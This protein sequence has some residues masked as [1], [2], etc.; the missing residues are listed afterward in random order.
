MLEPRPAD[1][2][3]ITWSRDEAPPG[4]LRSE[5]KLPDDL[6]GVLVRGFVAN[7]AELEARWR[8]DA[9]D[10]SDA[11]L[12][13]A[14]YAA[15]G[16]EAAEELAGPLSWVLWDS[17]R[18]RLLAVSDRTAHHPWYFR[19]EGDRLYL[20]PT[21]E[22]ILDA[23]PTSLPWCP[24]GAAAQ[25]R[26]GAPTRGRTYHRGLRRLE[27]GEIL[28]VDP[29]RLVR[30]RYWALS[31]GPM[32]A[33]RSDE[34]FAELFRQRFFEVVEQYS[35]GPKAAIT[36]SSGMD[37]TSVAAALRHVA[38]DSEL[39]A[40]RW[41]APS[42][43]EADESA[44]S[45]AVCRR[46][47]L[48]DLVME[49]DRYW[50]LSQDGPLVSRGSPLS[51]FFAELLESTF[52]LLRERGLTTLF[53]GSPGDNLLAFNSGAYADLLLT[54][55]WRTLGGDA[56]GHLGRSRLTSS[57]WAL[58]RN[59]ILG[60]LA[61]AYLPDWIF[62][63]QGRG[64]AWLKHPKTAAG[65]QG[66]PSPRFWMLPGRHR[67]WRMLTEPLLPWGLAQVSAQAARLG[68]EVR[69]PFADHRLLE[70]AA[71]LPTDQSTRG[72]HHKIVLRKAM[73][74]YL[75][76]EVVD[77]HWKT[78]PRAISLRGLRE[79]E[80]AT[81]WDLMTDMR[82]AE[83]GLVDEE[84]LRADYRDYLEGKHSNPLF[85]HTICLETWFRRAFP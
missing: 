37:S 78:Y 27:A 6:P 72:G 23:V 40:V 59:L 39:T 46:L 12:I 71:R 67:R 53:S 60:P 35:A 25:I 26:G 54:G 80:T 17:G 61:A 24:D 13:L 33:R 68:V 83:A 5:R 16:S 51:S 32:L 36:L 28:V 43:P 18:R 19:S 1:S 52:V 47:G 30:R 8:P 48:Q 79:R 20:A 4:L 64:P 65:A 62:S 9:Q 22:A 77:T 10:S 29:H 34:A 75:P 3:C 81:V 69:D 21:V 31:P 76:S 55:R 63:G 85:W 45:E 70:L 38:P 11:A 7:R 66:P 15:Q 44:G 74:R 58:V 50:P 84:S 14:G 56:A 42:L 2:W 41:V 73:R 49:A 57:R 82:A